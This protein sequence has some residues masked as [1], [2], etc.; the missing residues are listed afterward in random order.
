MEALQQ[1]L[2]TRTDIWRGRTQPPVSTV[3]TGQP[4]L[5]ECL[6]GHGWPCG[7]LTELQ[8]THAGCGEMSLIW[9]LLA[10]QTQKAQPVL[11]ISPPLIPCPQ[12]WAQAGID[13]GHLW[14]VRSEHHSLWAT[15]QALK[16]GLC[17]AV[18]VWPRTNRLT[19]TCL[20]RLQLACEH[21]H[22]PCFLVDG[23]LN[24][25]ITTSSALRLKIAPGPVVTLMHTRHA[26]A[27]TPHTLDLRLTARTAQ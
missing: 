22:A 26:Q 12:A 3:S 1:L 4:A 23:D 14:I 24:R 15:E 11:L 21:G 6:P 2:D 17:G 10:Q 9:P 7:Q 8:P 19:A 27:L 16:S 25:P 20:R 5:D 13:L 18:V